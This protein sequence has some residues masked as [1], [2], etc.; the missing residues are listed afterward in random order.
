MYS[1]IDA[2][3]AAVN[4]EIQEFGKG[5]GQP[6]EVCLPGSKWWRDCQV[7]ILP[8]AADPRN[9]LISLIL[10]PGVDAGDASDLNRHGFGVALHEP[11]PTVCECRPGAV[12]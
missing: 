2:L 9:P 12:H 4:G 11:G 10:S 6:T 8:N 3:I 5:G 7:T 1:L